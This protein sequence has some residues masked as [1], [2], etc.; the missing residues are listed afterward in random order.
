[1]KPWFWPHGHR[2]LGRDF[3]TTSFLWNAA[4]LPFVQH[5]SGEGCNSERSNPLRLGGMTPLS[6]QPAEFRVVFD[7]FCH[8]NTSPVETLEMAGSEP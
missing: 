5:L 7:I 1:M 3:R 2:P 6:T 4:D 8:R